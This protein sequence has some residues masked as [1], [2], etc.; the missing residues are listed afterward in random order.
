MFRKILPFVIL[1][2][3]TFSGWAQKDVKFK[4]NNFSRNPKGFQT[5]VNNIKAGDNLVNEKRNF[6]DALDYYLQANDFNPDNAELNFKIGVCYYHSE[7]KHLCLPYLEKAYLLDPKAHKDI[8]YYLALGYQINY[9]FD[10]AISFFEIYKNSRGV[11]SDYLKATP[12]KIEECRN[13]KQIT[14]DTLFVD[15]INLGPSINSEYPEYNP[16]ITADG[17]ELIFISRRKGTT[18]NKTDFNDGLFNEDVYISDLKDGRWEEAKNIGKPINTTKHDAVLGISPDGQQLLVYLDINEGDIGVSMLKGS[19]WTKPEALGPN[20]NSQ[21]HESKACWSPD[22]KCLYFISNN[23]R[24]SMGGRDIF[25]S[26]L[27]KDGTWGPAESIG[28]T[29]NTKY[30]EEGVFMHPD[31]RT[32]YFSSE[33]H[34]SMGGYDIFKSVKDSTGNW[35]EPVNVGYP[36]NTPG[37]DVFY[38]VSASGKKAY[39]ASYREDGFGLYDIYEIRFKEKKTNDT[40]PVVTDK[41]L[42]TILKGTVKDSKT[43]VP[44][45]AKIEIIDNEKNEVVATFTSNSATGKYLV[46]LPSGRNYGINVSHEAY[47][48]HSENFIIADTADY[49]EIVKDIYLQKIEVGTKVVLRN[50]FFDYNKATL[51]SESTAEL[52]K[53]IGVLQKEP[54]LR[55]EISGHTDNKGGME[56]NVKL[57]EERA[58]AVVDYLISKGI[59]KSRLEYKGYAYEQP[60]ATNDTEEGRQLNR[61]VE[62]KVLSR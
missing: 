10:K 42:V 52:D 8:C 34:N 62:F 2:C 4:A 25:V 50:I 29:I 22:G 57:S 51:R 13:A 15:I 44:V 17:E 58:K 26:K 7:K 16:L 23:P 9:N 24:N 20:I 56:Y 12:R 28:K 36:V 3:L 49:Q 18:G 61:R 55:I 32:L 37:D 40:T 47:L 33:G 48:F 31:G 6:R 14:Q 11:N 30:N 41:V 46:S 19:R 39:F 45:E 21:Y 60:I 5:A 53:L 59:D 35:T 38:T 54:L 1:I 27:E 43:H